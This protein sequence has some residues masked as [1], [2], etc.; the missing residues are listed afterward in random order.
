MRLTLRTLLAYLDDIIVYGA[1]RLQCMRRLALVFSRLR[2]AGLKLKPSKC[3]LF[4]PETL[5]LGHIVSAEGIKCDPKKVE[6][7]RDMQPPH[8]TI[9][10]LLITML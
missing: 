5:Y 4:E 9:E 1:T 10:M 6:A 8:D 7:I 3:A 2:S